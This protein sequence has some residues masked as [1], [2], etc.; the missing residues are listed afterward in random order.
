MQRYQRIQWL[1]WFPKRHNLWA[2]QNSHQC[3]QKYIASK[4]WEFLLLSVWRTSNSHQ[5]RVTVC[6]CWQSLR[7]PL[8]D[9]TSSAWRC[10]NY[11]VMKTQE[12]QM[13]MDQYLYIPFLVGWTSIY[14]LF[15]C[16]PGVQGFDTLP[17]HYK[18]PQVSPNFFWGVNSHSSLKS[19]NQF[20]C[21]LSM[22]V[23]NVVHVTIPGNN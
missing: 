3:D 1:L 9:N 16:S 21:V 20:S 18:F 6:R 11:M 22:D 7:F 23:W 2:A 15:W 14:Q 5:V 12:T 8:C 13:A 10:C 19:E 4:D 17:N